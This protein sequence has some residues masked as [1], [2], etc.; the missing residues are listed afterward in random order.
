MESSSSFSCL[1]VQCWIKQKSHAQAALICGIKQDRCGGA[2]V[3]L[4]KPSSVTKSA[5]D[6][7]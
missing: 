1:C 6:K 3:H 7:W 4:R 5:V 2:G